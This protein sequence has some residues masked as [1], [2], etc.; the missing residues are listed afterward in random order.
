M[1]GMGG[2]KVAEAL[3]D[4]LRLP[5]I[6]L[7]AFSG[8]EM[9]RAATATGALGYLV[10]PLEVSRIVPAIETALVRAQ[11]RATLQQE[12][13]NLSEALDRNREIDIAVGLLMERYALGRTVA[14]ESLRRLARN[15][16]CRVAE[17]ARRL[18]DGETIQFPLES[19]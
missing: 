4:R 16:R 8:D 3:R 17:L 18:I 14:F 13:A 1:P 2:I 6:F 12:V 19:Q 9:V 7:T 10:K 5:F 15:Q 11:E